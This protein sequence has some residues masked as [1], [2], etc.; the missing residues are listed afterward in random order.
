M[1]SRPEPPKSTSTPTFKCLEREKKNRLAGSKR[2][3]ICEIRFPSKGLQPY[4]LE[5]EKKKLDQK[6]KRWG[7]QMRALKKMSLARREGKG[8]A[9][10]KGGEEVEA[11]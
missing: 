4:P 7:K 2:K 6:E 8:R 10:I 5:K 3:V 1:K 9:L 11:S